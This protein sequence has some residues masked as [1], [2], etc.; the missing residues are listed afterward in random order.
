MTITFSLSKISKSQWGKVAKVFL[1]TAVS[2]G[3]AALPAYLLK[4]P[5]YLTLQMPINIV[6][7]TL[8]KFAQQEQQ[9]ALE[10]LP[11]NE[12]APVSEV[13]STVQSQLSAAKPSLNIPPVTPEAPPTATVLTPPSDTVSSQ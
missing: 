7:V 1:W 3:I 9:Q 10:D 2:L 4:N 5:I 6:L 12:Q 13:I 11:V 8:S